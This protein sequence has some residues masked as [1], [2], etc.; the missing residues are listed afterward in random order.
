M[1]RILKILLLAPFIAV[2]ATAVWGQDVDYGD[3][4]RVLPAAKALPPEMIEGEHFKVLD[5]V[6]NKFCLDQFR[7]QS[8]YGEFEAYGQMM[9]RIRLREI[10]AL[11]RIEKVKASEVWIKA[12]G[13]EVGQSVT[14]MGRIIVHPVR[15]AKGIKEGIAKR[16]RKTKRDVVEDVGTAT[17]EGTAGDKAAKLGSRFLGIEKS[18]RQWSKRL[19]VDPYTSNPVLQ[20]ELQRVAKI[21]AGAALGAKIIVP[22]LPG[23]GLIRDVY[24]AVWSYDPRELVELNTRSLVEIGIPRELMDELFAQQFFTPSTTTAL[25]AALVDLEGVGDRHILVEQALPTY[26]EPEAMYFLECILMA[27]WFHSNEEPLMKMIGG[28]GIPVGQTESGRIIAFDGSD[29]SHWREYTV[30]L[31]NEFNDAYKHISANR[32]VWIAGEAAQSYKDQVEG[33]GWKVRTGNR[34]KYL[35]RIPWGILPEEEED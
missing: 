13:R 17:G 18:Y 26:S 9:L 8:D 6:V 28:T 19:G 16:F 7:I 31:A 1:Q 20:N 24:S 2:A 32:E 11:G 3:A 25:V 4:D 33:L 12:A 21:D 15:T 14:A 35:P 10:A 5:P 29:F 30:S 22:R 27:A 23:T 34:V